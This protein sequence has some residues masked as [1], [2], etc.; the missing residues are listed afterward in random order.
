MHL[1]TP[2]QKPGCQPSPAPCC[3]GLNGPAGAAKPSGHGK[4]SDSHAPCLPLQERGNLPRT[5]L[6][7]ASIASPPSNI[8]LHSMHP[9]PCSQR[10]T[11][12][13]HG[14]RV[15]PLRLLDQSPSATT[16]AR[17]NQQMDPLKLHIPAPQTH[18]RPCTARSSRAGSHHGPQALNTGRP[19]AP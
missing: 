1:S 15:W 12:P 5:R 16:R 18:R 6:Q 14:P 19:P 8:H 17:H 9:P 10:C 3:H 13:W 4:V 7:A 2:W 11:D